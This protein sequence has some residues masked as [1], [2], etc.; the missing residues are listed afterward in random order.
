VFLA[1]ATPENDI[2]SA[3]M[4]AAINK[5]MRLRIRFLSPIL[6]VYNLPRLE[7]C[8]ERYFCGPHLLPFAEAK[9]KPATSP[10]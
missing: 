8:S 5:V 6:T 9:A 3:I 7:H 4:S 2:V 1:N 10:L